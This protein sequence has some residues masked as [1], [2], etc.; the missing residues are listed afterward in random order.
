MPYVF[1][2]GILFSIQNDIRIFKKAA[3]YKSAA[4]FS[5]SSIRV[6]QL[7]ANRTTV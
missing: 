2:P 3:L 4:S 6:A 7:V 5:T 1:S